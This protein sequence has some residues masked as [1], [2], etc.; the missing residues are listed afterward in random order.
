V[1][2]PVRISLEVAKTLAGAGLIDLDPGRVESVLE[3]ALSNA[4][5]VSM[6]CCFQLYRALYACYKRAPAI[7]PAPGAG[8][9]A[10]TFEWTG[11]GACR[12]YVLRTRL[13]TPEHVPG[14]ARNFS[15]A[16]LMHAFAG[17]AHA[18][19]SYALRGIACVPCRMVSWS[20]PICAH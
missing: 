20:V 8:E 10:F 5:N 7:T 16:L 12:A 17:C 6:P 13:E 2:G 15:S 9:G 4:V 1:T 11:G 14:S 19:F 18:C 3:I